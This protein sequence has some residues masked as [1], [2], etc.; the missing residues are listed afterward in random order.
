M[1][2]RPVRVLIPCGGAWIREE[3]QT[4]IESVRVELQQIG[5]FAAYSLLIHR[6][7]WFESSIDGAPSSGIVA[8]TS[9]STSFGCG[10][11]VHWVAPLPTSK[12]SGVTSLSATAAM[13]HPIT[14][15][16]RYFLVRGRLWRCTNPNLSES[17]R[18]RLT[19]E[20]MRARRAVREA[21]KLQRVALDAPHPGDRKRRA[22]NSK[23]NANC[24][25]GTANQTWP[26]PASAVPAAQQDSAF[27]ALKL[28]RAAVDDAKVALGERGT[29]WWSATTSASS[30]P[31]SASASAAAAPSL[32]ESSGHVSRGAGQH[33]ADVDT[34][35]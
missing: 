29:P 26:S 5:N 12:A 19:A 27:Q 16:G 18:K 28:A 3:L 10:Q 13:K 4:A 25:I 11:A 7:V 1:A 34:T 21:L 24:S 31:A 30:S 20:L 33:D 22:E 32:Q 23:V 35:A 14:P 8:G 17:E 15:D 2:H 9:A 6:A